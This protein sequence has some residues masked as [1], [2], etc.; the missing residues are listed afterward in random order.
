MSF[1]ALMSVRYSGDLQDADSITSDEQFQ[2]IFKD[3]SDDW[4]AGSV[5]KNFLADAV[6]I[7]R[8]VLPELDNAIDAIT[9]RLGLAEK[10]ECYVHSYPMIQAGVAR[11]S[12]GFVILL[13]SAAVEKLNPKEL[14]FVIG[15]EIGHV[16]Y[17][18]LDTP[19]GAVLQNDSRIQAKHAM[20]LLSWSRKK[21]ISADR[22]GLVCCGSLE[23]VRPP[24]SRRPAGCRFRA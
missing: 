14:E 9:N 21:E 13:G 6:R 4:A 10:C 2:E 20:R 1:D 17:G 18:H 8:N 3:H 7:D 5:R 15:H 22:A 23:A 24:C 16:V 19:V 12:S 11:S